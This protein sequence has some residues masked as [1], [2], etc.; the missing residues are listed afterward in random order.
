MELVL[1]CTRAWELRPRLLFL[2]RFPLPKRYGA[3]EQRTPLSA[4]PSC[5]PATNR[6]VRLRHP[7]DPLELRGIPFAVAAGASCSRS[8]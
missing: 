4:S 7:G 5:V 3:D 6:G 8:R 1:D 2:P